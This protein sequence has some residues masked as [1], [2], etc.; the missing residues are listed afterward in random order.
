MSWYGSHP[1]ITKQKAKALLP[2]RACKL[3]VYW[4]RVYGGPG[5]ALCSRCSSDPNRRLNLDYKTN[6]K[7]KLITYQKIPTYSFA[8]FEPEEIKGSVVGTIYKGKNG[9]EINLVN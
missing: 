7:G 8:P 2:K 9:T 5:S 3:C 1:S 6:L 4:T